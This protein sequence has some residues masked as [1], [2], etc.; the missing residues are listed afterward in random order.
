MEELRK[1]YTVRGRNN[2]EVLVE[3]VMGEPPV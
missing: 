1:G 2:L 3:E